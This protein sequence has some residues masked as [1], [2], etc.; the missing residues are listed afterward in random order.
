MG[1]SITTLAVADHAKEIEAMT[2][3]F[4][5]IGGLAAVQFFLAFGWQSCLAWAAA[6]Q[7]LRWHRR[8]VQVLLSLDVSW[9]DEHDSAGVAS[10]LE[11]DSSNVYLFMSS[12]LGFLISNLAQFV[13]GLLLAL[14]EGW[15][16]ALVVCAAM[17]ILMWAGHRMGKEIEHYTEVQQINFARASA[18]AEEALMAIRSV[19]SFGGEALE[20]ARFEKE[21]IPAKIGGIRSGTKIGA[22]WGILNVFYPCLYSLALWFGGHVLMSEENAGFEPARI[23]TVMLSVMVGVSALSEFSGFVPVMARAAVS[24]KAMK[25]VICR[26]AGDAG[27][28][29]AWRFLPGEL[30]ANL[31]EVDIIEF[32]KVSFRYPARLDKWALRS[33]SFRAEK[34]QK[35]ALVGESGCGKSTTIQLLERFYDPTAGEVL[36]N[37]TSLSRVPTQVWRQLVGYVGQ[38]PVLFATSIM[39]NLKALDNSV[40]DEQVIQAAKVAQIYDTVMQLPDGMDTH[41]GTGGGL[42]S[43]G[44]RQRIAIAR[45]LAKNPQVLLLDE[46]TSALDNE[47]ERMV[48]ATLDS[49]N[50]TMG[51]NITTISVAHRLSTIKDSDIIYVLKDGYC[52]EQGNHEQLMAK[53]GQ[54]HNMVTLQ[55]A[56]SEETKHQQEE[57]SDEDHAIEE[58]DEHGKLVTAASFASSLGREMQQTKCADGATA[59]AGSPAVFCRLL[60]MMGRYWWIW[61]V[62]VVIILAGAAS[63]PLEAV[64]FN[65]AV[66]SLSQA[67]L[68]DFEA[69]YEKLDTAIVGLSIV[70]LGSGTAVFAQNYLFAYKQESLCMILRKAAFART[71]CMDMSFFDAPENQ[72]GSILVSLQMHMN[73]VGQ[74][75]GIQLGNSAAALFT[76]ILSFGFSFFGCWELSLLLFGLMPLCGL[77]GLTVAAYVARMDPERIEAYGKAGKVTSEAVTSIRTVKAIG[78]EEHIMEVIDESLNKLTELNTARSWRLG[79]SLGL[80]LA[81]VQ[82]I[83]L[84]GFSMSAVCIQYWGFD[85]GQVLMSLF[86]VVF[87]VM[88]ITS[89][90]QHIPDAA[91][92]RFAAMEVFRLVD[93]VSKIDAT[94]PTGRIEDLGDGSIEFKDV[95][96]W[97]PH[98]A[99]VRVLKNVSFTIAKGQSV[100]FVGSSGSGKSTIIQLLQR[101]YD[102]PRGSIRIGGTELKELNVAWWRRQVGMVSQDP[103]LFDMS[104]E[105]NVKYG[106]PEA[107]AGELLA[108]A[109]AAHMDYALSGAVKWSERMGL[110][111]EKLSGGQKQRCALARA[112]IRKPEVMLLDEATSA[113]DSVSEQVVQRAMQEARLGRT[114]I[115]VA[116]RLSTIRNSD[117]IFVISNGRLVESGTYDELIERDGNLAKLAAG[118]L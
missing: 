21:L 20:V 19:A 108:A 47:S 42:L 18:V 112:L 33:F 104:L 63:M 97:Y 64:F 28:I 105:E 75:L 31:T 14:Y 39:R 102:P 107:T 100:A 79:L 32:R 66:V 23:I 78:A 25:Q 35:V 46:A 43:G 8:F 58:E 53:K 40:P 24:A 54:Y 5:K 57:Q 55:Q 34:G 6:K 113:L 7:A 1:E 26:E 88:S 38:E 73:R 96:F 80:N 11:S 70:G 106:Y 95:R 65:A 89:I 17:P 60:R 12:A 116:H 111:G 103:V 44:Q 9:Y 62:S 52:C 29:E 30:P 61:P 22:A 84:A 13:A 117:N 81:L 93:Q 10:K 82:L 74:M 99:E 4:I 36:V 45:A 15:Q 110:R 49:A 98:R 92:G 77:L 48:Q 114:T 87:G 51:R 41:V 118:S 50:A 71:V 67:A 72:T 3:E 86:C 90:V 56:R 2:P 91:S 59:D 16:L 83:F 115:T 76:C 37:E 101:F 85:A 109:E 27:A 68:G 94:Q 69:M